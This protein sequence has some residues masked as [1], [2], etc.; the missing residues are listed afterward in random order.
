MTSI[1]NILDLERFPLDRPNSESW[2]ALVQRC[3][4]DLERDGLC[5]LEGLMDPSATSDAAD[6]LSPLVQSEAY[7][8]RRQHNIYFDPAPAGLTPDHPALMV[9]ETGNLTLC[10]DQLGGSPVLALYE[11]PLLHRF[12]A[13]VTGKREL[14]P[15]GDPLARVNVMSYPAGYKLNWHFDRAEFTTTLL[16]Q[17]PEKGGVFEYRT[18]LRNA[19]NPNHGGVARLLRG[20]DPEVR[21]L[22]LIPGTLNVFR[23]I[24]TPHRVTVVEGKTDRMVAVFS[25]FDRPGIR[26]TADE[27]IGFYG[28]AS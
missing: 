2:H 25:Y 5:N 23:G 20:E 10:A 19:E 3:R 27:Q 28:R 11:W 8:H 16:L 9:L 12:L 22:S 13:A 24:N 7:E 14:H 15:M 18:D 1:G 26:F 17:K 21:Q 4:E 6:A